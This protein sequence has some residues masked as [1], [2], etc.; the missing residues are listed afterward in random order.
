MQMSIIL[1]NKWHLRPIQLQ[2]HWSC[3]IYICEIHIRVFHSSSSRG[4]V[5]YSFQRSPSHEPPQNKTEAHTD[6][7]C[8][9]HFFTVHNNNI[10]QEIRALRVLMKSAF[11]RLFWLTRGYKVSRTS[12][13]KRPTCFCHIVLWLY[14]A[15]FLNHERREATTWKQCI[16]LYSNAYFL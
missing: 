4:R 7:N 2:K 6:G 15:F 14:N 12:K 1:V 9:A 8:N 13:Y 10:S 3:K 5:R 11:P 16:L